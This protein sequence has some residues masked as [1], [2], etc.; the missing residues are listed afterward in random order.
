MAGVVGV[1]PGPY[2]LRE[3]DAMYT[4][5]SKYDWDH[6]SNLIAVI[7]EV[8]R[9]HEKRSQPYEP[10]EFHP[11]YKHK[12]RPGKSFDQALAVLEAQQAKVKCPPRR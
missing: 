4:G 6:T 2:T 7:A 10:R 3:L 11:H 8:N 1:H 5:R 9:N 12:R